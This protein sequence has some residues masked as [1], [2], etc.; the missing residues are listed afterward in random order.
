MIQQISLLFN[1]LIIYKNYK[2]FTKKLLKKF[3]YILLI[4]TCL[5]FTC[6]AKTSLK[7]VFFF[8]FIR[9]SKINTNA[10]TKQMSRNEIK[11][12]F[13]FFHQ[14]ESGNPPVPPFN[15]SRVSFISF[16][17]WNFHNGPIYHSRAINSANK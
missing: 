11:Q 15:Y 10:Q 2:N 16:F 6:I 4:F 12:Y 5:I 8:Q 9:L 7:I 14:I 13:I 3:Y 17:S 1:W